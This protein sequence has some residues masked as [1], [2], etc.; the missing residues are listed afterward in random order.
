MAKDLVILADF[1]FGPKRTHFGRDA[2]IQA[3]DGNKPT[4]LSPS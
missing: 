1:I 3:K 2:E 4:D